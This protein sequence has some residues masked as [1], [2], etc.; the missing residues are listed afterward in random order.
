ML[1]VL[2]LHL[3]RFGFHNTG[4]GVKFVALEQIAREG[5]VSGNVRCSESVSDRDEPRDTQFDPERHL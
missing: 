4:A 2:R 3:K 1:C 5:F